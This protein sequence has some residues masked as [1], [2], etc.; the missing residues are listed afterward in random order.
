MSLNSYYFGDTS[1]LTRDAIWSRMSVSVGERRMSLR[2]ELARENENAR[3]WE[4]DREN[5][6]DDEEGKK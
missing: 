3:K 5:E 6:D 4:V 2:F 1:S